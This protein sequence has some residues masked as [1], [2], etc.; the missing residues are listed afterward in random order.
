M[1]KTKLVLLGTGTPNCDPN[2]YQN[3]SAIIIN[4]QPYIIDC[5]GG[6]IQRISEA[7]SRGIAELNDS[8]LTR[9]FLTHL[10]PDHVVGLGDFIIAPWVKTRVDPVQIYGP[11]GTR[12]MVEHLLRAFQ[13]GIGEHQNGLAALD[14]PLEV[15]VYEFEEG[16]VYE[17]G[18]VYVESFRVEHGSLDAFG[19]RFVTEDKTIVHSGDTR[20]LPIMAQAAKG[21]DIL[22]HEVYCKASLDMRD[23]RWQRYHSTAHTSTIELAE[24]ANKAQP[25][26]LILNHSMTWGLQTEETMLK[27]ITDLYN[28]RVVLGNDLDVFE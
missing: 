7:E 15:E 18:N 13:I 20:A 19:L 10:H 9:L 24:I 27:E 5:G 23:P 4:D 21:A 1:S 16:F 25:G 22:I 12:N 11:V 2:R 8:K 3:A 28:G 14:A 17:D 6:T 26:L